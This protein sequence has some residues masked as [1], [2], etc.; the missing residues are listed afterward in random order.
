MYY[1]QSDRAESSCKHDGVV[2]MQCCAGDSHP[3]AV[4]HIKRT[5]SH[6]I[7]DGRTVSRE[8]ITRARFDACQM[9]HSSGHTAMRFYLLGAK[10]FSIVSSSEMCSNF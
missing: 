9:C 8:K 4:A 7:R 1:S 6:G 5:A 10:R 3:C 2:I